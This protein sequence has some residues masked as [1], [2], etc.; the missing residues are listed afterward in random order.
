MIQFTITKYKVHTSNN[1]LFS[2]LL[3]LKHYIQYNYVVIVMRKTNCMVEKKEY[4][5]RHAKPSFF[6][7]NVESK[8]T[9]QLPE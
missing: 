5:M 7:T 1:S 6:S 8:N 9:N 2:P 4:E 3:Y